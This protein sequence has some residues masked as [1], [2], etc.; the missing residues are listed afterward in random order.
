MTN[1]C[2]SSTWT[3]VLNQS[4]FHKFSKGLANLHELISS[5]TCIEPQKHQYSVPRTVERYHREWGTM[6]LF[7]TITT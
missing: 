3:L 5:E 1:Y 2:M 7:L 4:S 6:H